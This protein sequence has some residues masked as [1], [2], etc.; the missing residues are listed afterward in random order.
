[1]RPIIDRVTIISAGFPRTGYPQ[2]VVLQVTQDESVGT[3]KDRA[4]LTEIDHERRRGSTTFSFY[5]LTMSFS[6]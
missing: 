1:M 4:P 5:V 3:P 2:G 6:A